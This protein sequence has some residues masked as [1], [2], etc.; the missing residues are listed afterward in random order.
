MGMAGAAPFYE[1]FEHQADMG[2]RGLG[3]TC[4][5]AFEQ[6]ALALTAVVVP[7]ELVEAKQSVTVR[8]AAADVEL[9]LLDWLNAV[10]YQM[11]A[12]RM[13]FRRFKVHLEGGRVEG[14]LFGEGLDV[15]R[16]QPG[17]EVKAATATALRVARLPDGM[18]L[19]QLVVD[20]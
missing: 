11:S 18:W 10:V 7:L 17:V 2:V 8:C 9:L 15:E 4:E 14:E 5:E 16:H 12:S 3:R 13:I 19:A 1:H 6:A 20:V